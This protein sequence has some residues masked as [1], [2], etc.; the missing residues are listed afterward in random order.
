MLQ[1]L[2][3]PTASCTLFLV[4]RDARRK[5]WVFTI[6]AV[7]QQAPDLRIPKTFPNTAT[8]SISVGRVCP[9]QPIESSRS[10]P[11]QSQASFIFFKIF[12]GSKKFGLCD[13]IDTYHIG[14]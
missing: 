6:E 1:I 3:R 14:S 13:T 8:T 4:G 12:K 10:Q 9:F 7:S 5:V 11:C 2:N